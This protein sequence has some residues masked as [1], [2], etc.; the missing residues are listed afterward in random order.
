MLVYLLLSPPP[1][2]KLR[3]RDNTKFRVQL[4]L[5]MILM[6]V[7]FAI[8]IYQVETFEICVVASG[9]LHYFTLVSAMWMAA[10][11]LL[12]LLKLTLVISHPRLCFTVTISLLCWRKWRLH[13]RQAIFRCS[14]LAFRKYIYAR[15]VSYSVFF[16]FPVLPIPVVA[17]PIVIDRDFAIS[18]E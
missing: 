6:L 16:S 2:S 9:L 1:Y 3:K 4:C 7:F 11:A 18:Y 5:A 14:A 10:D 8:G 13:P 17:A 15:N 12:M